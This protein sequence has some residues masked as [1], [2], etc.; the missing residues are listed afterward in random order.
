MD[1]TRRDI[2]ETVEELK[3]RVG[4]AVDWRSYVERYPL[5]SLAL[6]LA[7]GILIG[8]RVGG[9]V[10][11][12]SPHTSSAGERTYSWRPPRQF[13]ESWARAG[14]RLESIVNRVID[15]AG[16]TVEQFVVPSLIGGFSRLVGGE[17]GS[18]TPRAGFESRRDVRSA[19]PGSPGTGSEREPRR[20]TA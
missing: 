18:A 15:E 12:M 14:S 1:T 13:G 4:E 16:D 10:L 19:S 5:A 7:A 9:A 2:Q 3:E 17:P 11:H 6:A 8:R 20:A